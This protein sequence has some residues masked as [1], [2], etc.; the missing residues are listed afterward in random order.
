MAR[1]EGSPV[2]ENRAFGSGGGISNTGTV[3]LRGST[4]DDNLSVAGVGNGGGGIFNSASGTASIS[5][6]VV[7]GNELLIPADGG[8]ISNYGTL[9]LRDS[10]VSANSATSRGGGIYNSHTGD[11][12]LRETTVLNNTAPIGPGI[13]N[14][15]GTMTI[16]D[17]TIQP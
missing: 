14:D 4:I 6:T 8:G 12:D 17:S 9:S 7:S 5:N 2:S 13:F 11:A 16:K 15:G 3:T 1:A 10:T